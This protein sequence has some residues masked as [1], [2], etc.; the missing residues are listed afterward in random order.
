[1]PKSQV[2]G[3]GLLVA[4]V[5]A[6][7]ALTLLSGPFAW[8]GSIC[9]LVLA[10]VL[11]GFD[12]EGYRTVFESL[13][14]SAVFALCLTIAVGV[15]L[16]IAAVS[17]GDTAPFN[18]RVSG[19]WMPFF[20]VG[21]TILFWPIDRARMSGRVPQAIVPAIPSTFSLSTAPAP[22]VPEPPR[23]IVAEPAPPPPA[24]RVAPAPPPVPRPAPP[25]PVAA[26]ARPIFTQPSFSQPPP[27]P[28]W[29]EPVP[30]PPPVVP[31]PAAERAWTA[32][33]PPAAPAPEPVPA[34]ASAPP[35][36]PPPA[37]VPS[38]KEAMIYVSLVGEGMNVLR[39][40]RAEHLGRDF[41]KIVEPM[42]D[43]E[44]WQFGPGQVVR[45]K[46][47]NLSSGKAMVATEEAPR[48]R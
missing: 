22:Q 37:P 16:G 5:A 11:L 27:E 35:V 30:V 32:A 4:V 12:R 40:V 45:A 21:I 29:T 13:A 48:S 2:D 17:Q 41:Y 43:G 36:L 18:G 46:K 7:L 8:L 24:P 20:W 33:P 25:P 26:S 19:H 47:K 34:P 42:P 10:F 9:G 15:L 23:A 39:A 38:G 3:T 1:M 14:F 6:A 28:V 44:T 31:A